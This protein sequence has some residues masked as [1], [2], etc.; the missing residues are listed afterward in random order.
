M[1]LTPI[2]NPLPLKKASHYFCVNFNWQDLD[3]SF[4]TAKGISLPQNMREDVP[5][6]KAH[7][8]GGRYCAHQALSMMKRHGLETA[9]SVD[10]IQHENIIPIQRNEQGAPIWPEG[11]IGSITHTE[12]FIG[13][14]VES[15]DKLR[16][17]GIDTEKILGPQSVVM[18][19]S[20]VATEEEKRKSLSFDPFEYF[21]LIYSAKESIFKCLNP[22]IKKYIEFH[23]VTIET[24]CFDSKSFT[25][26]LLKDLNEEFREGMTFEGSFHLDQ[27]QEKLHTAFELYH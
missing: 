21:T 6:K 25:F 5:K 16:G 20:L 22:I 1:I 10:E 19:E 7:F 17:I 9:Q 14:V 15:F 13:A 26:K 11:I 2:Q 8:L 23:D 3:E 18:V 12:N 4:F 24:V 27:G